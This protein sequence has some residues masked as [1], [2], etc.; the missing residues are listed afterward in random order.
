VTAPSWAAECSVTSLSHSSAYD[1]TRGGDGREGACG[2]FGRCSSSTADVSHNCLNQEAVEEH[3]CGCQR[4]LRQCLSCQSFLLLIIIIIP[5]KPYLSASATA[6]HP[7]GRR[8]VE[9][10]FSLFSVLATVANPAL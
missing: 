3:R 9:R 7:L 6:P 2:G 1:C 5:C 4:L 8:K 10:L